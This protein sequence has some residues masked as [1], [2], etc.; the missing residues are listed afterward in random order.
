MHAVLNN[1]ACH[2]PPGYRVS[3]EV[4]HHGPSDLATPSFFVEIGSTHA[5]WTD[6]AAGI[7]A[8][9]SVLEAVPGNVVPLAGFGGNHYAARQTTIALET[10]AAFGHVCPARL[11]PDLDLSMVR[12]MLGASGAVAAYIDKKSLSSSQAVSVAAML[13]EAGAVV[14][15]E[16]EL[17]SL[18]LIP[19]ETYLTIRQAA[20][21]AAPGSRP[22]FHAIDGDGSPAVFT[23]PASLLEEVTKC[24]PDK[25]GD[26]LDR[27]PV[28]HLAGGDG[29]PLP[30]FISYEEQ[31]S[32]LIHVLIRSCVKLII[33][34]E[35]AAIDGEN[36]VIR[37]MRFDPGK[38]RNLGVPKGPLF[39]RLAGGEK[40]EVDGVTITPSMVSDCSTLVIHVPG[41]ERYL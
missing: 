11:V 21:A 9:L 41:L 10:R 25:L 32:R 20:E 15:S 39:G 27:L 17:H 40:V 19:W 38:A 14:M 23:I 34:R 18:K 37:K 35:K 33:N 22:V 12:E 6:E 26:V 7:A 16:S 29:A 36:L 24:C 1:L 2:A 13:A 30:I 3:Y 8:A 31:R 5:E 4:T 28:V